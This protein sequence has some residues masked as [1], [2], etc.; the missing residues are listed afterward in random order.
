MDVT[1]INKTVEH[2][3]TKESSENSCHYVSQLSFFH[4]L[5]CLQKVSSYR[6]PVNVLKM[7]LEILSNFTIIYWRHTAVTTQVNKECRND[8]NYFSPFPFVKY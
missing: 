7:L 6:A 8:T 3:R 5:I 1:I 4:I 2:N